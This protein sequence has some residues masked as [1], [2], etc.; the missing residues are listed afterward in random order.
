MDDG[1]GE[2][3]LVGHWCVHLR[4]Q[5]GIIGLRFSI[6]FR[7]SFVV[8]LAHFLLQ[9]TLYWRLGA[10]LPLWLFRLTDGL[11]AEPIPL[12]VVRIHLVS[13]TVAEDYHQVMLPQ[14]LDVLYLLI[15]PRLFVLPLKHVEAIL[16]NVATVSLPLPVLRHFV[17]NRLIRKQSNVRLV[18]PHVP[19]WRVEHSQKDIDLLLPLVIVKSI[20]VVSS[21]RSHNLEPRGFCFVDLLLV[22]QRASILNGDKVTHFLECSA[23]ILENT[24]VFA[25]RFEV[26]ILVHQFG[27]LDCQCSFPHK[28]L[29]RVRTI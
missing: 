20:I 26:N 29:K 23:V 14:V 9:T 21:D 3:R 11:Y 6:A 22:G 25:K 1:D 18:V 13:H 19:V 17:T 16:L 27:N 15:Q 8:L 2:I 4:V 5:R 28:L 10:W 7:D 12:L 24:L